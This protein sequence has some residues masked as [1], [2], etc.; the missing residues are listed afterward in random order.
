MGGSQGNK[1]GESSP[2][3]PAHGPV[4]LASVRE[5]RDSEVGQAPTWRVQRPLVGRDDL[6][7]RHDHDPVDIAFDHHHLERVWPRDT[8]S[9]AIERD[10]L[11]LVH[12][13]SG[14][15]HAGVEAMFGKRQCGSLFL[16]EPSADE[17]IYRLSY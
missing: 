17:G 3:T 10:G 8:V 13:G 14:T 9:T 11:I 15:D 5:S 16:S 12:R 6:A 1:P 7:L 2:D 4:R